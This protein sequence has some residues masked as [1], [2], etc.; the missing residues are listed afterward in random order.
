MQQQ[1][2]AWARFDYVTDKGG[3]PFEWYLPD[4]RKLQIYLSFVQLLCQYLV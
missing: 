1:E 4:S 3:T 2:H